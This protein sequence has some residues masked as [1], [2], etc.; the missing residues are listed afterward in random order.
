MFWNKAAAIALGLG[1]IGAGLIG[2]GGG[3]EKKSAGASAEKAPVRVTTS[4]VTQEDWPSAAELTG[5]IRA[6]TSTEIAARVMGYVREIRVHTGDTVAAGQVLVI[7]DSRDLEAA[8]RQAASAEAEAQSA[9]SELETAARS[10]KA[11]L[12]LARATHRRMQD[13]FSKNSLSRQEMDEADMR[14][15][16]AEAAADAVTS[17]RKQ[18]D[19]RIAQA[20][21]AVKLAE[22]NKAFAEI[23]APFAGIVTARKAEPGTLASPGMPLLTLE[24]AGAYRAEIS[25]DES[26]LREVRVGSPLTLS[27]EALDRTVET[28]VT[29]VVPAI[30]PGSRGFVV[31]ADVGGISGLRSGM[32]VRAHVHSGARRVLTVDAKA[33]KTEG[34]L[35]SALAVEQGRAQERMIRTGD[36]RDGRVEVLSGLKEGDVVIMNPPSDLRDGDKVAQ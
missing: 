18:L 1:L 3:G 11:Q 17:K 29:E 28:R 35:Q 10:A 12:D 23:R 34:Q 6:R 25:V 30:D 36:R 22:V 33:V 32:F 21:E 31:K 20:Q 16:V 9:I 2:C 19:A 5:E 7:V 15:R 13:L 14:L 4:A 24:Q 27:I 8:A 26:K